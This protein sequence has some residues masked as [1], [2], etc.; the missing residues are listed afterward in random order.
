[1]HRYRSKWH[2]GHLD[3]GSSGEQVAEELPHLAH[4]QADVVAA[5]QIVQVLL[6]EGLAVQGQLGRGLAAQSV[7]VPVVHQDQEVELFGG[8]QG[9]YLREDELHALAVGF[10]ELQSQER[11]K[12]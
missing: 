2:L 12:L 11:V 10:L 4:E 7:H 5:V 8:F 3:D 9:V 1:M 6:A